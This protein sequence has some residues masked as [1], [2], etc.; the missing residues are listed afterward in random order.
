[1]KGCH[2]AKIKM[3]LQIFQWEW[4]KEKGADLYKSGNG[5][6]T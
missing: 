2:M 4:L 6:V 5:F 3:R 1:M